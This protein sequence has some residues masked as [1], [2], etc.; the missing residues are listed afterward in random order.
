[1]RG[2]QHLALTVMLANLLGVYILKPTT[3]IDVLLFSLVMLFVAIGSLAPDIDISRSLIRRWYMILPCLPLLGVHWLLGSIYGF[4]HRGVMHSL[5]G[6]SVSFAVVGSLIDVMF[7][8]TISMAC[9]GGFAFGYL[10]HLIEDGMTTKTAIDW[11]PA[12]KF[13]NSWKFGVVTMLA[14]VLL[15]TP[16]T[17]AKEGDITGKS[18][19]DVQKEFNDFASTVF[20]FGVKVVCAYAGITAYCGLTHKSVNIVKGLILAFAIVFVLTGILTSIFT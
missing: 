2:T 5:I 4:K 1:M 13:M 19:E 3:L 20:W 14:L 16:I 18:F 6:W 8:R 12:P 15:I 7:G 17:S 9:C 11:L 10:A